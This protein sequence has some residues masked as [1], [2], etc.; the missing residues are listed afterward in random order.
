MRNC[1][2]FANA[3]LR[4]I[5]IWSQFLMF[6]KPKFCLKIVLAEIRVRELLSSAQNLFATDWSSK[7]D[8]C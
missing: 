6:S 1:R 8:I 2:I 4:K 5:K 7:V 3:I